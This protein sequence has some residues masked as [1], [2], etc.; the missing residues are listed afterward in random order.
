MGTNICCLQ[1]NK[2]QLLM[3]YIHNMVLLEWLSSGSMQETGCKC[4]G[5]C[6]TWLPR[7]MQ[8]RSCRLGQE[9]VS[10]RNQVMAIKT[11]RAGECAWE[12]ANATAAPRRGA[13]RLPH[14]VPPQMPAALTSEESEE[15]LGLLAQ[16]VSIVARTLAALLMLGEHDVVIQ[17]AGQAL[18]AG[19]SFSASRGLH[20]L[21]CWQQFA[22]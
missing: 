16:T 22:V 11:S 9:N 19:G 7:L 13:G 6:G 4:G 15:P 14:A 2:S 10:L 18:P 1:H 17:H 20:P 12:P 21:L 5:A 3:H 8:C